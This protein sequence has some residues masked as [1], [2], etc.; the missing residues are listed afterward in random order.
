MSNAHEWLS[1]AQACT[2]D[3]CLLSGNRETRP[4]L[5]MKAEIE[6]RQR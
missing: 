6:E 4:N 2:N 3:P 1:A 5:K